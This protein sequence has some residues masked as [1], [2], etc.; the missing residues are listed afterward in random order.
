[1]RQCTT[2]T[3]EI[4]MWKA[5]LAG[6]MLAMT[7]AG[8]GLMTAQPAVAD[9]AVVTEGHIA[10]LKAALRLTA[11]QRRHWPAVA[12]ALR[13]LSRASNGAAQG[14]RQRASAAV[15]SANAVRRVAAAARPLI[16]S[17]TAE[18]KQAGMQVIR[19]SG[20]SHLASA[21]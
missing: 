2:A 18:Q 8:G 11:E 15:G 21:L 10:R 3:L 14:L 7:I 17:L 6:V 16:N 12:A 13:G 4:W 19:A 9:S 20:L 1:M 5:A